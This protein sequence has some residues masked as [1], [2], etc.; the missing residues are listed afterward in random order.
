M[1]NFL[2]FRRFS[3]YFSEIVIDKL[4]NVKFE[5]YSTPGAYMEQYRLI[6]P[7]GDAVDKV[8][9]A[10]AVIEPYGIIDGD[11]VN[12][13]DENF[14]LWSQRPNY[15]QS[16]KLFR[17]EALIH[18]LVTGN[19]FIEIAW[20][21][22]NGK[23]KF[24][25]IK[26][27]DP[28]CVSS[29]ATNDKVE[30]YEYRKN[31]KVIKYKRQFDVQ[32]A[33]PFYYTYKE[34]GINYDLLNFRELKDEYENSG[35]YSGF[36]LS[37]L[38]SIQ[39]ELILYQEGNKHNKRSLQNSLSAKKMISVETDKLATLFNKDDIDK[40]RKALEDTYS[41]TE[42]SGKT[43][44]TSLPLKV[45]DLQNPYV[46]RDLEFN[47]GQRRLRVAVYNRF[48]IPLPKVE[49]EFTSNSNM[50]ESNLNFYDEA[51]LPQLEIYYD[52]VYHFI[53]KNYFPE[54]VFDKIHYCE[55]EIPT[56]ALRNAE[57][58]SELAKSNSLTKNELRKKVGLAEIEGLNAVYID[59]NQAPIGIDTNTDDAIGVPLSSK[60]LAEL[61]EFDIMIE[62]MEKDEEQNIELKAISDIDL[63]PTQSMANN[64]ARGL[65]WRKQYGRG[66]T[67]VGVA[68]A[69]DIQ[70]RSRLSPST[71]ARMVSYFAR[72]GVNEGKN[73]KPNGEPT[74]HYIAWNL[75]GGNS[76]RSWAN[77]K[78]NAIKRERGIKGFEF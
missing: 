1:L 19:N 29:Y 65:K 46:S 56:I 62:Q 24:L 64:A 40:Y 72:H 39:D 67:A 47:Q 42:N 5:R 22:E 43:L 78:W 33:I 6:A 49:G 58:I 60:E 23:V 9:T 12:N 7:L 25:E 41:G 48:N 68:R 20:K 69:R 26:N 8:A 11:Y 17:K 76:G 70:N 61:D 53:F 2:P 10:G 38:Y 18:F 37:R 27:L 73:K 21:L 75:W 52:F 57:L 54:I 3:N 15:E 44:F 30:Y 50:K 36:G 16:G 55:S 35:M 66:G 4:G 63:V 77:K 71:V 31:T 28:S 59:G 34:N 14:K 51:V 45:V 32:R 13:I 74:N